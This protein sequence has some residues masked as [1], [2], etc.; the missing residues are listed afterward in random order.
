MSIAAWRAGNL[1]SRNE[2]VSICDELLRQGVLDSAG[3]K[4]IQ[5]MLR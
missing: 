2:A 1:G 5:R 4:A 3:Y